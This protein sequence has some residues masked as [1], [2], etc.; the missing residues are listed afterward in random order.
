MIIDLPDNKEMLK[1]YIQ[2]YIEML[3]KNTYPTGK[4]EE[5]RYCLN[6]ARDK[7]RK[8]KK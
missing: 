3:D 2:N 6:Q 1:V 4:R 5:I 8:M 7:L